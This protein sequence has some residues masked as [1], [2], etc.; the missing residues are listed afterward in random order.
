M[1]R[2]ILLS[3]TAIAVAA[4]FWFWFSSTRSWNVI[5]VTVDTLRADHL[6]C[7]NH[8]AAPTP[9]IDAFA[10]RSVLFR[11]A[12]SL[13]PITL[14]AHTA[15]LT[16]RYP[17]ELKLFNNGDI[18]DYRVPMITDFF[19]SRH[20]RTAAFVSLGVLNGTFGLGRGFN[21]YEDKM[22]NGRYYNIASEVN[23]LALPWIEKNRNERF[24]AWIHYSDPH[25]PY[26]PAD[27][28]PDTEL[29]INGKS[30]QRLCLAK[31]EKLQFEFD[32]HP[33]ENIIEFRAIG[34][35]SIEGE[36]IRYLERQLFVSPSE[37]IRLNFGTEWLTERLS[38]FGEVMSFANKGEI[39]L[40]NDRKEPVRVRLVGRGGLARQD[41]EVI[42]RN[43][44]K[45]VQYV[46]E[47]FGQLWEKLSELRLEN[48]TIVVLTADHG[49]GL[50]DRGGLGHVKY[51]YEEVTHVPLIVYFPRFGRRGVEVRD[52]V[53]HLDIMPTILDLLRIKN[54]NRMDG[55]SLKPLLVRMVW[56]GSDQKNGIRPR[57]FC[58]TYAPEARRNSFAMVEGNL[59]F[60]HVPERQKM[61]WEIYNLAKD[62]GEQSNLAVSDPHFFY[63]NESRR[64]RK[65][66]SEFRHEAE[67][68][69]SRRKNPVLDIEQQEILRGLG[70]VTGDD[71]N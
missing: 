28:P 56:S 51:M 1:R 60:I 66:L 2:P 15:I 23:E 38:N 71:Q 9:N 6:S 48:K 62:P 68:A 10:R 63:S 8:S 4:G 55:T 54:P 19:R 45:E 52:L 18:F 20:Y 61:P 33:G 7:Y 21:L 3:M 34:P 25:E 26:V 58:S 46:D 30:N 64:L 70:Y 35:T 22:R 53:N 13:I 14:P 32:A 57:T 69:H 36:P 31:R 16:S 12:Y 42:K 49:E 27:A 5:L 59:K 37:N 41:I 17:H 65:E 50:R 43:Y 67:E 39:R 40:M 47:Q 44:S 11:N 29:L 24:F